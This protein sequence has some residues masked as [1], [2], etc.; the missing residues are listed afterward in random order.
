MWD[1]CNE[2]GGG[3]IYAQFVVSVIASEDQSR[4]VWPLSPSFG[5]AS[6]VSTLYGTP[7][8]RALVYR[9]RYPKKKRKK[10]GKIKMAK[11]KEGNRGHILYP[12]KLYHCLD[13][14]NSK[15][16]FA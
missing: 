1:G 3:G 6:G 8:G 13:I 7:N 11:E 5:W 16:Y 10:K 9:S 14:L 15:F 4:V 2:C 12:Y